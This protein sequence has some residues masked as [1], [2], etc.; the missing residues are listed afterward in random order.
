MPHCPLSLTLNTS[1]LW[2]ELLIQLA[3]FLS[4]SHSSNKFPIL[5][6]PRTKNY[7]HI[8]PSIFL[9]QNIWP[10]IWALKTFH[11]LFLTCFYHF[12]FF[13]TSVATNSEY[14]LFLLTF[15]FKFKLT[16]Q[17]SCTFLPSWPY[18]Q[19]LAPSNFLHRALL[20]AFRHDLSNFV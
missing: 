5:I 4:L 10:L 19:C 12:I 2:P 18:Q 17:S 6:F 1:D 20:D 9:L 13:C 11:S 7:C 3:P 14:S 16:S 15:W 8:L